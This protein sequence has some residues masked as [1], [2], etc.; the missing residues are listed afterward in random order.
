M[1]FDGVQLDSH[2]PLLASLD[3]SDVE[4]VL[5]NGM[6]VNTQGH[7]LVHCI[8]RSDCYFHVA[9]NPASATDPDFWR[10]PLTS[11]PLYLDAA[12]FVRYLRENDRKEWGRV[13]GRLQSPKGAIAYLKAAAVTE[14]KWRPYTHNCVDFV[15][16]VITAGKGSP[17]PG[18]SNMP[19]VVATA[20]GFR[21]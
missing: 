2:S 1:A 16:E 9:G 8:G 10:S 7:A 21:T 11:R 12:G 4:C 13:K 18:S 19:K 5:I 20:A 6:M 14:W 17:L 15:G 3:C